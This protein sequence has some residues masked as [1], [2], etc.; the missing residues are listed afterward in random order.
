MSYY[1]DWL[2]D[3]DEQEMRECPRCD[4]LVR[5]HIG[6]FCPGC[7]SPLDFEE[8]HRVWC[9]WVPIGKWWNPLSW[10]RGYYKVVSR[11]QP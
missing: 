1:R 3:D 6:N 11:K 9:R 8:W 5:T 4:F 10:G 7:R 2:L